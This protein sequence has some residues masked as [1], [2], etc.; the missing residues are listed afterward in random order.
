MSI[1]S[2]V[3]SLAGAFFDRREDR[4]AA[5][6]ARVFASEQS[7]QSLAAQREFAQ[8]G[9]RWRVEDAKAAGLHPLY[10]TG[11]MG[12]SYTPG[13]V[14]GGGGSGSN[15]FQ[16]AGQDIS[17]A[18]QAQQTPEERALHAAT[19]KTMEAAAARDFAQASYWTSEAARKGQSAGV[20]AAFPVRDASRGLEAVDIDKVQAAPDQMIS[21]RAGQPDITA[22]RGHS[23]WREY[24]LGAF[25]MLA[26]VNEEG[27]SEGLESMPISM[28]PQFLKRNM[29]QYGRQWLADFLGIGRRDPKLNLQDEL[30]RRGPTVSGRIRR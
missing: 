10:A 25:R 5:H 3:G 7:A 14:V 1:L 23:G 22:G 6:D 24:N 8:H 30:P 19:L 11:A 16:Q 13:T 15:R 20:A 17:R 28:W 18:V 27:W 12:A 29:E 21:P 26:P 9:I 4:H 2:A